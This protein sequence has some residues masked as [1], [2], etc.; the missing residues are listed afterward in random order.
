[1][2]YK[3]YNSEKSTEKTGGRR[4]KKIVSFTSAHPAANEDFVPPERPSFNI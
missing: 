2:E 4:M 1:M 3:T